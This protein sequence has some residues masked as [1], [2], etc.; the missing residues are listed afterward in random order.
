MGVKG[1][2]RRRRSGRNGTTT[3]NFN[4]TGPP[5]G[6][7]T[8][9]TTSATTTITIPGSVTRTPVELGE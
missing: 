1:E 3:G 9:Y 6:S 5:I 8:T 2:V 7:T 4:C